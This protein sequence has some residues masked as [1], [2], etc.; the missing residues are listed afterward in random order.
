VELIDRHGNRD[1]VWQKP[2]LYDTLS[3]IRYVRGTPLN[4]KVTYI[5]KATVEIYVD[6]INVASFELEGG[7]PPRLIQ[8]KSAN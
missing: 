1:I 5:G 8:S 7:N 4:I 3:Q 6:N 2:R